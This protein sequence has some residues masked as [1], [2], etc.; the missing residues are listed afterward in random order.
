M[1]SHQPE[2]LLV[3]CTRQWGG[4]GKITQPLEIQESFSLRGS[5]GRERKYECSFAHNCENSPKSLVSLLRAHGRSTLLRP[6][7]EEGVGG[8]Q[9]G[10]GGSISAGPVPGAGL[11]WPETPGSRVHSREAAPSVTEKHPQASGTRAPSVLLLCHFRCCSCHRPRPHCGDRGG[12]G[13]GCLFP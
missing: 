4:G 12:R 13:G 1:S 6:A 8:P 5:Q 2:A 10:L 3:F 9:Q 7:E 11:G